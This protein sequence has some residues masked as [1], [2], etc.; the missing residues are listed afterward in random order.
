MGSRER[1]VY[2]PPSSF[3]SCIFFPIQY[4]PPAYSLLMKSQPKASGPSSS[5]PTRARVY[6]LIRHYPWFRC[7]AADVC[8]QRRACT[9]AA[10]SKQPT[11]G[12]LTLNRFGRCVD[13]CNNGLESCFFGHPHLRELSTLKLKKE[14]KKTSITFLKVLHRICT[15]LLVL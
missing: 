3:Y 13:A 10:F 4:T 2:D 11:T 6:S 8:T 7:G 15:K 1:A 14:L 12:T 5:R 9:L